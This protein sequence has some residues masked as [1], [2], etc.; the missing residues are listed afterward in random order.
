MMETAA[1]IALA[2]AL[3]GFAGTAVA[4]AMRNGALTAKIAQLEASSGNA[5]KQLAVTAGEFR[6]YK[7]R[8]D[9]Q[10]VA[11]AEE[12]RVLRGD[13]EKCSAPGSQ[14]D[15]LDGLL[16]RLAARSAS[17]FGTGPVPAQPAAR[18]GSTDPDHPLPG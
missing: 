6:D 11:D 18:A 12:A 17:S 14:R 3:V 7:L 15:R 4:L 2:L 5:E 16:G 13:L 8:T 1:I 9:A 10:L